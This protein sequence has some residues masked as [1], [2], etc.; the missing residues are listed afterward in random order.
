MFI[1]YGE[2]SRLLVNQIRGQLLSISVTAA[3][4]IDGNQVEKL[5][6][7]NYK[8]SPIDEQLID[9]LRLIRDANRRPDIFIKY[10]YII[11][12]KPGAEHFI[13][14][15][16]AEENPEGASVYGDTFPT[17]EELYQN[18]NR[19]FVESQM[20]YDH[21]GT[22]ITSYAPIYNNDGEV[23]ATLGVDIS[24]KD[25]RSK[26][27]K[28]IIYGVV[29]LLGSLLVSIVIAHLLAKLVTNSLNY[30][31]ETVEEIGEGNLKARAHLDTNDEFDELS[32]AINSMARGLEERERFKAWFC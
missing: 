27:K 15:A 2:S 6:E 29:A 28:L 3:A 24:I 9:Q 31:C 20:T 32:L 17:M 30:L 8:T 23:V 22:W 14:V 1:V 12:P 7:E 4:S 18:I 10:L 19:P 26:M 21:W 16:D 11:K 13:Y 5:N 25:I